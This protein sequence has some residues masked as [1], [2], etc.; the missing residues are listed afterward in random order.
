MGVGFEERMFVHPPARVPGIQHV[1]DEDELDVNW[2]N[3]GTG[4]LSL[5]KG[6]TTS[7]ENPFGPGLGSFPWCPSAL[8]PQGRQPAPL[9]QEGSSKSECG[10]T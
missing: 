8:R 10:Q 3:S 9:T 6:H 4:V 2:G 1:R 7:G 5:A